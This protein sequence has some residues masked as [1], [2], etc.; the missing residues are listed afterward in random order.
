MYQGFAGFFVVTTLFACGSHI[1]RE[2]EVLV[3]RDP[4]GVSLW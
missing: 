2:L 4:W 3:P 1:L